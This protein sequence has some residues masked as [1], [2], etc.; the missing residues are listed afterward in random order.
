MDC[1]RTLRI[2]SEPNPPDDYGIPSDGVDDETFAR[3]VGLDRNDETKD[4]QRRRLIDKPR[5][6]RKVPVIKRRNRQGAV[7]RRPAVAS[8]KEKLAVDQSVPDET[9]FIS[10]EPEPTETDPAAET[11][12]DELSNSATALV[13][14]P[15]NEVSF[16]STPQAEPN[17]GW[18]AR[19]RARVKRTR[20][21][22][23]HIDPWSVLKV[24]LLLYACLY[25]AFVL[26]GYLLWTAA[27]QSGVISN[28][29]SFVAEVGSYEIWEI[30][31]E[32]IF[33]RATV[34]GAVLFVGAIAFNVL[35]TIIFNLISDL[36][37]GV[38]VTLL[39][40]DEPPSE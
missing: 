38:R 12:A 10:L 4:A 28:I 18:L 27:V 32:E 17:L 20:R 1:C 24:S 22:I 15:H 35:L 7:V 5:R 29:E 11:Q 9:G 36:V 2:V 16:E 14:S 21:T 3:A 40:E 30:N 34:I 26:A 25:G 31:G 37:G 39:E 13:G 8:S 6:D 23:R 19:R 33:Q